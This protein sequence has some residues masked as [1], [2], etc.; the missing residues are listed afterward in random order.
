MKLIVAGL[1]L[2]ILAGTCWQQRRSPRSSAQDLPKLL[3]VP[4]PTDLGSRA[5]HHV[6]QLVSYGERWSGSPGWQQ[7]LEYIAAELRR[8]G[9][10]PRRDRWRDEHEQLTFENISALI[11]GT[12]SNRIVIGAHH[13]TKKTQGHDDPEHNFPF[14]GANDSGS[15]VGLLLALAEVLTKK[16]DSGPSI[17][18]VFFDGEE[19]IPFDWDDDR[20][21][22]GSRRY[23]SSY[24]RDILAAG[25]LGSIKAFILLDMVGAKDLQID[26][27]DYSDANLNRIFAAAALATGHQQYFFENPQSVKDDHL[28]F[29]DAGIPAIDL[30]DI[31]VNE[32]WHTEQDKL[33]HISALSLQI[34]GEVVLTALP[35]VARQ[36]LTDG[37]R[38]VLPP[39]RR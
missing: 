12:S 39:R 20:A 37:P 24:Q 9:L 33:E 22:F 6:T 38:L 7:S 36:Y 8:M 13:D 29:L 4:A 11:P 19:S 3:R 21:L 18:V 25:K 5:Y 16:P 31:A 10:D 14:V 35:E 32:H 34:V 15:G 2:M 26:D 17:E 30:I 27:D 28:A 1:G 23:I